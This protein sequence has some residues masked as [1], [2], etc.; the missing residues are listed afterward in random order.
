M[1]SLAPTN[2]ANRLYKLTTAARV[3]AT[4]GVAKFIAFSRIFAIKALYLEPI[5]TPRAAKFF[6]YH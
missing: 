2:G 4:D 6:E 5:A 3:W 1:P